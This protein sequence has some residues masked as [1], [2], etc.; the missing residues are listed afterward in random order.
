LAFGEKPV[1]TAGQV[2]DASKGSG[3]KLP[4][5]QVQFRLAPLVKLGAKADDANREMA[6]LMAKLLEE[7]EKDH[8]TLTSD[9][10]PNG[11]LMRIEIEE[12]VLEAFG[13]AVVQS[14]QR[15]RR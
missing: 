2:L 6:E 8:V 10:I 7:S 4:A 13:K 15:G 3:A 5:G 14:M 11:S 9:V 1:A 12:G